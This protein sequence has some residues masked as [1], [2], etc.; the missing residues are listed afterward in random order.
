MSLYGSLK[1]LGIILKELL[2]IIDYW[3]NW[4]RW[5]NWVLSNLTQLSF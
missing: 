3:L 2:E 5:W 4:C 1:C